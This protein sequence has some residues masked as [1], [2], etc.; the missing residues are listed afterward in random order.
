M[1]GQNGRVAE[2]V[3]SLSNGPLA[4]D[5]S[6]RQFFQPL[7]Q[8]VAQFVRN[9]LALPGCETQALGEKF[10]I[11]IEFLFGHVSFRGVVESG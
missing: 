2:F 8:V 6:P 1:S 3:E 7:F 10:Q 11:K 4:G 5:A 9:Q